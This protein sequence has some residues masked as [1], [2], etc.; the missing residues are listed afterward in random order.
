MDASLY[1]PV[2]T[3]EIPMPIVEPPGSM[4]P[5]ILPRILLQ[6]VGARNASR[7]LVFL[8]ALFVVL[9]LV[10]TGLLVH[11]RRPDPIMFYHDLPRKLLVE[12]PQ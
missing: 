7:R 10:E 6:R 8:T 3:C 1:Q 11:L 9:S 2:P 4:D 12:P 5:A